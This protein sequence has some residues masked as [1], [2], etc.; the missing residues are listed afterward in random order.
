MSSAS[1]PGDGWELGHR[2]AFSSLASIMEPRTRGESSANA[3]FPK[4]SIWRRIA[5]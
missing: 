3:S 4:V 5:D 1:F 2:A